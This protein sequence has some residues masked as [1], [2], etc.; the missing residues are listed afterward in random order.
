MKPTAERAERFHQE[1]HAWLE[2]NNLWEGT[3][4][5][6]ADE[7]YGDEHKNFP[8]LQLLRMFIG[9]RSAQRHVAAKH[10]ST[11]AGRQIA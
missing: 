4:W 2:R 11:R 8:I 3:T 1:L 7:Y 10:G 6:T 5:W 9:V